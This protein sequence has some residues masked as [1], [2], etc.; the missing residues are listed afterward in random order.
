MNTAKERICKLEGM[1]VGINL[2]EWNTSF[3]RM[4]KK[5]IE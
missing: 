1:Y 2:P 5:E 3:K 4:K